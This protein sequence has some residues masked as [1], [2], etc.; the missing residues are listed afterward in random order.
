MENRQEALGQY[1]EVTVE[2]VRQLGR[3][4]EMVVG[5]EI[6][7]EALMEEL[8]GRVEFLRRSRESLSQ[9]TFGLLTDEGFVRL[10]RH[11][12]VD[13]ILLL[14]MF[15]NF[16]PL[17]ARQAMEAAIC[18]GLYQSGNF[19]S[20]RRARAAL[21]FMR[22]QKIVRVGGMLDPD[23]PFYVFTPEFDEILHRPSLRQTLDDTFAVSMGDY[24]FDGDKGCF[25]R[26]AACNERLLSELLQLHGQM[27]QAD[28]D[29]VLESLVR[30]EDG[31]HYEA[32]GREQE[33]LLGE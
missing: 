29:R 20:Q 24:R 3:M 19:R 32:G 25:A 28:F 33:V 14:P 31:W 5:G 13:V 21:E 12:P 26:E 27:P 23:T 8:E 4:Q 15:T 7:D 1:R 18:V 10:C 11:Y 16:G 17:S 6:P 22:E 9:E 2:L 30:T